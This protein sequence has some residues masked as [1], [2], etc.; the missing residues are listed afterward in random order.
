MPNELDEVRH[1][2]NWTF[3]FWGFLHGTF[4]TIE[5][6]AKKTFGTLKLYLPLKGILLFGVITFAWIFFRAENIKQAFLI[7]GSLENNLFTQLKE[8]I[9][10]VDLA[11]LKLLYANKTSSVFFLFP[12]FGFMVI[13]IEWKQKDKKV[14]CNIFIRSVNLLDTPCIFS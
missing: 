7:V 3:L 9:S 8:I 13:L 12:I 2:A 5:N 6:L 11:R 4:V 14:L 1:R 10:N